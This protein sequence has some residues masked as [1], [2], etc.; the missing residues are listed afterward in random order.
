MFKWCLPDVLPE[1]LH[2]RETWENIVYTWWSRERNSAGGSK[3]YRNN[4]ELEKSL[5]QTLKLKRPPSELKK[6]PP[7]FLNDHSWSLFQLWWWYC[8]TMNITSRLSE[9]STHA[10]NAAVL[11][12]WFGIKSC[13][14]RS[15]TL[16]NRR[17]GESKPH[18]FAPGT[19]FETGF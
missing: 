11:F 15:H 16:F 6:E 8:D 1:H 4:L 19:S 10:Q 7:K 14:Y 13:S 12:S 18:S 3:L 9:N 5:R 17:A 2:P